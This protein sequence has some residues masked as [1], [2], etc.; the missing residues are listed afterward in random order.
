MEK[1]I[2]PAGDALEVLSQD[3]PFDQGM[4]VLREKGLELITAEQLAILRIRDGPAS[5]FSTQGTWVA[6][7]YNYSSGRDAEIIIASANLNPILK[8]PVEATNAHRQG[9]EF[10]LNEAAWKQLRDVAESD[11]YKAIKSGALLVTRKALKFEIP[12]EALGETPETVFLFREQ[13]KA[14]GNWLKAQGISAVSQWTVCEDHAK[15][16]NQP[17]GR[18]LWVRSLDDRSELD[19]YYLVLHYDYGRVRGVRVV[20]AERAAPEVP[21]EVK[22]IDATVAQAI[23]EG[24]GFNYD[25]VMYVPVSR[26]AIEKAR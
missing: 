20:P 14:Y 8:Q 2:I 26:Q 10:Y 13:A 11:P 24:V 21:Q 16:Q 17:F 18:A 12:V 5:P 6:E 3:G 1:R 4:A 7:N 25:G 15:K 19:G 22:G 9:E 23:Q